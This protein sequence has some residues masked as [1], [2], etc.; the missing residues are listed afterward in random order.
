MVERSDSRGLN[1]LYR[2]S[3]SGGGPSRFSIR[4]HHGHSDYILRGVRNRSFTGMDPKGWMVDGWVFLR[5]VCIGT[6][7]DTIE[8]AHVRKNGTLPF[9]YVRQRTDTS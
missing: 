5:A 7:R 3:P 9:L 6:R 2:D 1:D 8:L 4:S